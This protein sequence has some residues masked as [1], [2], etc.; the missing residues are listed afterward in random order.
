MLRALIAIAFGASLLVTPNAVVAKSKYG[1]AGCGLG[2][3]LFGD[4]GMQTS[5]ATTNGL[6]YN[7]MFGITSGTSNCKTGD[8]MAVI[9]EQEEFVAYNLGTLSKEIAQGS[10][11]T[12]AAYSKTLGCSDAVYGDF[13][14]LL[15]N[16]YQDI[17]SAPGAMAVLD[18]TKTQMQQQPVLQKNCKYLTL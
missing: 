14:G 12:L 17:F 3:L 4:G 1:V 6:A 11:D 10:G 16:K 13:S 7:Q 18:A 5:A 2:S 8:E 15:K 9:L